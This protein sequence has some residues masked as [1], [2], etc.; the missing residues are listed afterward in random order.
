LCGQTKVEDLGLL[1]NELLDN[2]VG[3]ATATAMRTS[4]VNCAPVHAVFA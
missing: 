1:D 3:A 2:A 4:R